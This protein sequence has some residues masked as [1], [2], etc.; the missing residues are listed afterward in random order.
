MTTAGIF[1]ENSNTLVAGLF[2]TPVAA[3]TAARHLQTQMPL[4]SV[5]LVQPGDPSLPVQ[6]EPDQDG[7]FRTAVRSHVVLGLSGAVLGAVL[8]GGLL[9]A[10][11]EAAESS[12]M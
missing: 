5:R 12:P 4:A 1:Q 10:G 6:L 3:A 9:S 2:T 7:I 8:A 11:W